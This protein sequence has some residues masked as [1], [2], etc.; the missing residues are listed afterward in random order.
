[1]RIQQMPNI[2]SCVVT[3]LLDKTFVSPTQNAPHTQREVTSSKWNRPYTREKAAYPAVIYSP[4]RVLIISC[5]QSNPST[6][7]LLLC[8][9]STQ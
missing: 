9:H 4:R 1:M 6:L 8:F 5:R 3:R 2:I 7:R